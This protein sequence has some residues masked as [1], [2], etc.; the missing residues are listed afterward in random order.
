MCSASD[1]GAGLGIAGSDSTSTM[2]L[3][4]EQAGQAA[5]EQDG[6]ELL[7]LQAIVPRLY[8]GDYHA[9]QSDESLTEHSI[10]YVVSAMKQTYP[11][12]PGIEVLNVPVDDTDKTNI[13]GESADHP[14]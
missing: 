6:V 4:S 9:S 3:D 7:H 14:A 11:P 1:Q 8:I 10:S 2:Q 12:K 13:I 5:A